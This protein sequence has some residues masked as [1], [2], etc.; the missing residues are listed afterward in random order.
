MVRTFGS[1]LIVV[2]HFYWAAEAK[3]GKN[4]SRVFLHFCFIHKV[5]GLTESLAFF[6]LFWILF[7]LFCS[8]LF[9]P[10]LRIPF[11]FFFF[12]SYST[13]LSI[14]RTMTN[15]HHSVWLLSVRERERERS[16]HPLTMTLSS[17]YTL[18]I[19]TGASV[20]RLTIRAAESINLLTITA[21]VNYGKII[22]TNI[23][24]VNYSSVYYY[25]PKVTA[26]QQIFLHS[27]VRTTVAL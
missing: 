25:G 15:V 20:T 26:G 17:Q 14:L 27:L 4:I 10:F 18:T 3:H 12:M 1:E 11:F 16:Q 13:T 19:R 21:F 2:S 24:S 6:F 22:T 9:F 23:L 7:F 8:V 5:S